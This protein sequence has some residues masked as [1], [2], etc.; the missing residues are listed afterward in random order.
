MTVDIIELNRKLMIPSI[1]SQFIRENIQGRGKE[2][3]EDFARDYN[4]IFDLARQRLEQP[5][6]IRC[7]DCQYYITHCCY[8]R[9]HIAI[10]LFVHDD[11]YCVWAVRRNDDE[12]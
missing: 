2:D 1:C 6:S 4:E 5:E 12:R 10:G 9:S 11:D 3:A 8:E 7:K